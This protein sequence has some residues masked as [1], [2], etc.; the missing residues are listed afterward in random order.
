[1]INNL[2]EE[3][4]QFLKSCGGVYSDPT[5]Y[6]Q[7]CLIETLVYNQYILKRDTENNI[8]FFTNYFLITPH[9]IELV[10]RGI[11]PQEKLKGSIIYGLDCGSKNIQSMKYLMSEYYKQVPLARGLLWN[12][13][14][15]YWQFRTLRRDSGR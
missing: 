2:F 12:H 5:V 10:I 7:S 13:Q 9:D 15:K 8:C 6:M 1:M 3:I 4:L 14:Y 11:D